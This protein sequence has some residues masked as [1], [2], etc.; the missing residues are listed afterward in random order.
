MSKP[1]SDRFEASLTPQQVTTLRDGLAKSWS[2][3]DARDYL[4]VECQL[5][6]PPNDKPLRRFYDQHVRP[7]QMQQAELAALRASG[8]LDA[9][10]EHR[11]KFDEATFA[12][13]A[14]LANQIAMKGEGAD[15]DAVQILS[16]LLLEE[17]KVSQKDRDLTQS[18]R[19][20][21]LL[22]EQAAAAKAQLQHALGKKAAGGG[23]TPEALAEIEAAANLL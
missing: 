9:L 11:E 15:L 8:V 7:W 4:V 22:E 2:Y 5:A 14:K 13:L 17:R 19:K 6:N 16:K 21:K 3:D 1:R 10:G 12:L 20:L 23:L 18:D